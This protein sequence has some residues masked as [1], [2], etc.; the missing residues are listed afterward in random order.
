L[1]LLD[2]QNAHNE[3]PHLLCSAHQL[4]VQRQPV[5]DQGIDVAMT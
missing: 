4:Y 3:K 1:N 5:W 2:T